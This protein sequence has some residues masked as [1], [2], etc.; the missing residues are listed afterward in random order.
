MDPN[1]RESRLKAAVQSPGLHVLRH[2][3]LGSEHVQRDAFIGRAHVL[4]DNFVGL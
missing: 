4:M 3:P 1:L 2:Q